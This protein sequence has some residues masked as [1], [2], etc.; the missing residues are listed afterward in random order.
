[1]Q[2]PPDESITV[3]GT[4]TD[5]LSNKM[6]I[7]RDIPRLGTINLL[8]ALKS[9]QAKLLIFSAFFY[10]F[11]CLFSPHSALPHRFA[12]AQHVFVDPLR[13]ARLEIQFW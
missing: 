5:K 1:M 6:H 13:V 7:N 10:L 11:I 8:Q 9:V 3:A 12:L 4:E 2:D